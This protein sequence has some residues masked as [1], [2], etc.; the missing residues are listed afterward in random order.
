MPPPT[1]KGTL[2][3]A[4]WTVIAQTPRLMQKLDPARLAA[5]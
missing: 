5:A 4:E 1:E 2:S 3:P